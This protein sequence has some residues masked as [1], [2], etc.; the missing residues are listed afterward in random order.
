MRGKGEYLSTGPGLHTSQTG[1]QGCR[2]VPGNFD[3][4]TGAESALLIR[5]RMEP[6]LPGS[7]ALCLLSLV[8]ALRGEELG[9]SL[10]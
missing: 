10:A 3:T 5:I 7:A 8:G 2:P 4:V 6:L 9:V 1:Q